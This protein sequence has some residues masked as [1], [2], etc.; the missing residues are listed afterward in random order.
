MAASNSTTVGPLPRSAPASGSGWYDALERFWGV[1]GAGVTTAIFAAGVSGWLVG[2]AMPRGPVTAPQAIALIVAGVVLGAVAG[3]A[4]RSRWAML[5]A[6]ATQVALFEFT[7]RGTPGS[8]VDGVHLDTTYGVIAFIAG[9]GVYAILALLPMVL[10]VAYGAALA[11]WLTNGTAHPRGFRRRLAFYVRRAFGA[12]STAAIVALAIWIALPASTPAVVDATG[13]RIPGSINE[14]TK[15]TLGGHE[16]WIQIR[17]AS[18]DLPVLLYLSGG[19]G[20]SDLALSRALLDDLTHD[21]VVVGWDQRGTGK[22]Y[23][24]LDPATLT[25]AQAVSDTLELTNYLRARFKE[26]KI[27]LM[28]ESW[29]TILGV[30]AIQKDPDLYYAYIGSGQMVDPRETDTRLYH[31]VIAYAERTGDT[32]LADKMRAYGPPPYQDF[33]AYGVVMEQYDKLAG[34]Y[35]PPA[36][37]ERRGSASGVGP[38]GIFGSEYTPMEKVN[39]VRGLLDMSAVMYPQIQGI[40][41]RQTATELKVPVYLFDGGHELSARRDLAHEWFAMVK[42]P[43]KQMFTFEDAGHA[44]AFEHFQDLHRILV[45][46]VL[47]Q[48]YPGR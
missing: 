26:E 2:L 41:F 14:L 6:P 12:L 24:G 4:M 36:A 9:R 42:A 27:Y 17:A 48:T 19:P 31:D 37:Y 13:H 8:T 30:L 43:R 40:D 21:F 5:L 32:A 16:Q 29:G 38:L 23:P 3:F 47:P 18:P 34:D 7:R 22:S 25:P 39:V 10:G 35:T 11:R 44:V 45:E 28:G 20:Q 1:R 46:T 15:V 33:W